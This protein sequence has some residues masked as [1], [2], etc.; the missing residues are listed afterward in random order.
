MAQPAPNEVLKTLLIFILSAV[1]ASSSRSMDLSTSS[2]A[3]AAPADSAAIAALGLAV[4]PA[5]QRAPMNRRHAP[6]CQGQRRW[7][8]LLWVLL[9]GT[10]AEA[11]L[12]QASWAQSSETAEPAIV[13]IQEQVVD[14]AEPGSTPTAPP[15]AIVIPDAPTI[16]T[17]KAEA[18][19]AVESAIDN[20]IDNAATD[21]IE[22][23]IELSPAS[24]EAETADS[25]EPAQTLD[26]VPGDRLPG[27]N[28]AVEAASDE[29]QS[30]TATET[31]LLETDR[32]Y[33]ANQQISFV[34][35][36]GFTPMSTQEI[37]TKFPGAMPPQH[38]YGNAT[39]D[40]SV[41]VSVSDIPLAPEQLPEVKAFLEDYLENSVPGF[42]WLEHD[43]V[44]LGGQD[45]IKLEFL[46]EAPEQ[47]IHN[48]MYITSLQ[49]KLL[50]FNFNAHLTV[51]A[52]LR[53][54]LQDSRNSIVVDTTV[55]AD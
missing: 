39:R 26:D 38:A 2:T 55:A 32:V 15:E 27:E 6:R 4:A 14:P 20:A 3:C 30:E 31:E 16:P 44:N 35:P 18:E 46:S 24:A 13:Q 48:D 47:R 37:E 11:S 25:V 40:V 54:L 10:V 41:G 29:A 50:G 49:G 22:E 52:T 45:W 33:L 12:G 53:P 23:A 28:P 1:I 5:S 36:V 9:L 34:P 7:L 17:P 43:F 51:D 42:Q 21:A 8:N 19:S